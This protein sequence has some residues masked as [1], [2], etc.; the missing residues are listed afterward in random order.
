MAGNNGRP[1]TDVTPG[2]P[3]SNSL[4]PV[5]AVF[6]TLAFLGAGLMLEAVATGLLPSRPSADDAPRAVVAL[7]GFVF[8]AGAGAPYAAYLGPNSLASRLVG[9]IVFV[10]LTV[11]AHWI[12]FGPGPRHFSG[13]VSVG[14]LAATGLATGETAGRAAF[15]FGALLL[16]A[17]IVIGVLR[18]WRSRRRGAP[19][20]GP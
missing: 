16:D 4:S 1:M 20:G 17:V 18:W 13:S 6:F 7:A 9:S 11:I 8:L 19:A 12:A 5:A 2:R 14:G 3:R 10:S 15:G